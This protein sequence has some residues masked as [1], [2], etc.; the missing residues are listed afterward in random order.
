[1]GGRDKSVWDAEIGQNH[2]TPNKSERG[3]DF[4]HQEPV[5]TEGPS[6]H[7][8]SR[9]GTGLTLENE[10]QRQIEDS[11][12]DGREIKMQAGQRK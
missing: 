2:S 5:T 7:A 10:G 12:T 6:F 3:N 8:R 4:L 9:T 11:R 1:M